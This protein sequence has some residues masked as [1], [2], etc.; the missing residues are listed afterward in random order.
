MRFFTPDLYLSYNS[1]NDE[2]ADLADEEW[3]EALRDYRSHLASFSN[4]M[5]PRVKELAEIAC[6]HDA[7]L[8]S[9]QEDIPEP[10]LT[11]LSPFPVATISLRQGSRI[12]VLIY[13]LWGKLVQYPS[14]KG[15]PFSKGRSH[16]LYDEIDLERRQPRLYWHRVLFS[17]GRV[18]GVPFVDAIVQS[19]SEDH[20][21][22][23]I[24][25]R[26]RA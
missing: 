7:E 5:N 18:I 22:P 20:P 21:E 1:S 17:D 23:S 3:E 6:L 11:P 26:T 2:D 15:W 16:W 25:S 10:F 24:V 8:L 14:P 12:F 9:L 19:F 13:T 4:E